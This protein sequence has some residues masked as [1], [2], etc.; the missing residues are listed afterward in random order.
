M[1][2]A[3]LIMAAGS[4]SRM[5]SIK[6]LLK[7]DGKTLLEKAIETSK[8]I[9]NTRIVCVLGAH[10][11]VIK[12]QINFEGVDFVINNEYALGL[13]TSIQSGITYLQTQNHP[14]EGVLILLADQ[15][16]IEMQY[17]Q[18]MARLFSENPEQ[19]VASSYGTKM[20]VPAI[21]PKEVLNEIMRIQGD[22]GAQGFLQQN[23]QKIVTP[24]ISVN[25]FDLDTPEDYD[26]YLKTRK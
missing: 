10:A 1:K 9:R 7:I 12:K 4:S 8:K 2:L 11:E 20:G 22:K 23:K 18:D 19:I 15:P 13:S 25:L 21:F 5:G 24:E 6:Q 3:I 26:S 14:F 16:A 17:Y